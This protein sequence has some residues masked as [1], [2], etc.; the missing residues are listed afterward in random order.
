MEFDARPGALAVSLALR[1][2]KYQETAAY[3][4]FGRKPETKDGKK[5]FEWESA[6]DM[7]KY[8]KMSPA[9]ITAALGASNYLQKWVD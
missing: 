3:G 6:K 2:P 4:H 1:E 9:E 7:S 8:T 5:F